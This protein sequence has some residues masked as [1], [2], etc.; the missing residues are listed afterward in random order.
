MGGLINMNQ[1]DMACIALI[2]GGQRTNS[3]H[4]LIASR[5]AIIGNERMFV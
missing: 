3:G 4:S 1:N 2:M 5:F